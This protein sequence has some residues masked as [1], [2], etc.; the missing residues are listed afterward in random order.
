MHDDVILERRDAVAIVTLNRP[1]R[2]NALRGETIVALRE[3][4]HA[5]EHDSTLRA[6]V[7]TGAGRAFSAGRDLK[8][9]DA[10]T[11]S[12][13]VR[14]DVMAT[15]EQYQELTRRL[16]RMDKVVI[17]AINGVAVGIGAELAAASDMRIASREAR[18]AFP[19]VRRGLFLTNGVLYRL[20]RIVGLG[21]AADWI[22]SGRMVEAD[23]LLAAGF[24][25]RIV[26]GE[27]LLAT[28]LET[29]TLI[30]AN[31]PNSMR[32]AKDLL[33][34]AY[35]VDLEM[36]LQLE[37]EALADCV[38]SGDYREGMNAFIEKR[39]PVYKGDRG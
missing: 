21:R 25:S 27:S 24:V 23:E 22:L 1:V 8:E 28:A 38:E 16:T 35:E 29:A 18:I 34:R 13:I 14:D 32:F 19:E 10:L 9:Q 5:V 15:A 39:E 20:P 37:S 36:M 17:C 2:L 11:A 7:L 30:A 31:A 6:L 26:D 33:G 12:A 4:L 3:A